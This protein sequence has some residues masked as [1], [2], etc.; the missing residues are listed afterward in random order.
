MI[1]PKS[2]YLR[3]LRDETTSLQAFRKAADNVSCLLAYEAVSRLPTRQ[4]SINTPNAPALGNELEGQVVLVPILRSGMA[5]LPAFLSLLP[6]SLVGVVGLKRDESSAH[7]EWYYCKLP[8]LDETQHVIILD[9][10]IATGGTGL[11]VL[12]K[13]TEQGVP[14]QNI[15]YV[16]IISSPEGIDAI[17]Y[18]FPYVTFI[19]GAVDTQLNSSHY[20]VP[21]LGDFGDR[22]FGTL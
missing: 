4:V 15:R 19:V 21:G 20:I 18:Q 14:Q 1:D 9:P 16:S 10:M 22:Y 17:R 6:Q 2:L 7:A 3:I 12:T 11:E 5:M 8:L 13:L